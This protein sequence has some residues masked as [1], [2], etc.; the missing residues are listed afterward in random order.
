MSAPS[1]QH[2]KALELLGTKLAEAGL[3]ERQLLAWLKEVQAVPRGIFALQSI[4][5]SK[6]EILLSEWDAIRAQLLW[7]TA[8]PGNRQSQEG[9]SNQQLPR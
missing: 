8:G 7:S 6:L 4:Q 9:I 3:S 1:G 2:A 5:T